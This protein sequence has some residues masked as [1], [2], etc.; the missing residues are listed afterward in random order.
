MSIEITLKRALDSYD[1]TIRSYAFAIPSRVD[2][3][4][5]CY[6][7]ISTRPDQKYYDSNRMISDSLFYVTFRHDSYDV[8][9]AD[10]KIK[11]LLNNIVG[12]DILFSSVSSHSDF[13]DESTNLY[14]RRYEIRIK[15]EE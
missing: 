2:G 12:E 15:H 10:I 5:F 6:K 1:E 14:E 11:H 4:A 9:V 13:Y 3:P 8:I 7:S